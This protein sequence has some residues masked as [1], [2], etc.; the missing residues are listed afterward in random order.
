MV[1]KKS[2]EHFVSS[3]NNI[4]WIKKDRLLQTLLIVMGLILSSSNDKL[5]HGLLPELY[6]YLLFLFIISTILLYSD[7]IKDMEERNNLYIFD[8]IV[9]CSFSA[10]L[11]FFF[12]SEGG[13]PKDKPI[14]G[15]MYLILTLSLYFTMAGK[16]LN[17]NNDMY[18]VNLLFLG[19]ICF[20]VFHFGNTAFFTNF[21]I[22]PQSFDVINSS[23]N[24]STLAS[25][26]I[27]NHLLNTS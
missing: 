4:D 8:A 10:I 23:I 14:L 22:Y 25:E 15:F 9:S 24:N 26:N 21:I 18:W 11:V 2:V 1:H 27:T 7:V 19:L 16:N 17:R 20:M 5:D 12:A 13:L 3:F 6:Y